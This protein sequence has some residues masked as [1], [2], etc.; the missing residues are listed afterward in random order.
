MKSYPL[1]NSLNLFWP[2]NYMT[3]LMAW[4]DVDLRLEQFRFFDLLQNIDC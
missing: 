1:T 2:P 4:W 3:Y